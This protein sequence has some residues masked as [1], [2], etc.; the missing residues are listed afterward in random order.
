MTDLVFQYLNMSFHCFLASIISDE[1]QLLFDSLFCVYDVSFLSWCIQYF[2]FRFGFMQS[3]YNVSPWDFLWFYFTWSSVDFL[4]VSFVF[5]Q[6]GKL[7]AFIYAG[8]FSWIFMLTVIHVD[9]FNIPSYYPLKLWNQLYFSLKTS[10][11]HYG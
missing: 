10:F 9:T 5:P 7:I 11:L 6:I 3:C 1:T 4:E 8:I 2:L